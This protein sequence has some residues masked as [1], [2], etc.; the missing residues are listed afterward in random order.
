M[1]KKD[2]TLVGYKPAQSTLFARTYTI[3][4]L[5]FPLPAILRTILVSKR[6]IYM[7]DTKPKK[8]ATSANR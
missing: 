1:R 5:L 3:L 7:R 6:K 2:L 8:L 4:H